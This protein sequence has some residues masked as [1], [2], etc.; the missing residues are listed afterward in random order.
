MEPS[1]QPTATWLW[2]GRGVQ[3][4]THPSRSRS[5]VLAIR[6]VSHA[7]GVVAERAVASLL[8]TRLVIEGKSLVPAGDGQKLV[9]L[10]PRWVPRDGPDRRFALNDEPL[11]ALLVAERH[12]AVEVTER[13]AGAVVRPG[14]A[15]D[16]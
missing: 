15:C 10:V 12:V 1:E 16:A 9:R 7:T 4:H 3:I 13:E 6:K 11:S 14:H 2:P 5:E 8:S